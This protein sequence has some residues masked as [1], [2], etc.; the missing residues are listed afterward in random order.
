MSD[1]NH[2][3]LYKVLSGLILNQSNIFTSLSTVNTRTN[4]ISTNGYGDRFLADDG[5]YKLVNSS[6]I[7]PNQLISYGFVKSLNRKDK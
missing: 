7:D 4:F 2:S 1:V 3:N 5:T 6:G